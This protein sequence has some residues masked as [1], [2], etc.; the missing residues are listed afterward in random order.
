MTEKE[1]NS[2]IQYCLKLLDENKLKEAGTQL[3]NLYNFKPVRLCWYAAK[4]IC[5]WKTNKEAGA[6]LE[7]L[8]GKG[9]CFALYPAFDMLTRVYMDLVHSCGDKQDVKRH[10]MLYLRLCENRK[11]EDENWIIEMEKAFLQAKYDFL[12]QPESEQISEKLFD[13]YFIF[14]NN[15]LFYLLKIYMKKKNMSSSDKWEWFSEFINSGFLSENLAE[16]EETPFIIIEDE[17]SDGLDEKITT[18]ILQ[19]LQKK[20]YYMKAPIEFE[21]EH[22]VDIEETAAISINSMETAGGLHT[23]YPAEIIYNGEVQGDNREYILAYLIQND[24]RNQF[25]VVLTS[26]MM[27]DNFCCQPVLK[28]D[29]ERLHVFSS[30]VF[31]TQ[32][33][34]GW[35]G[36]YLAY[37]SQIHDMDARKFLE[38]PAEVSYSIIVPARNS[39]S[40]LRYTLMTCLNQ[41]YEGD[42][43]IVLSD[44]STPGNTEVYQL[45]KELSDPRIKYYKTPRE[46]NLSRS[47]EF[48]FLHAK[49]EF[50]LS[51]GSDDG[52]LPWTL[53]VLDD[54]RKDYPDEDILQWERGFYAWPGFAGGQQH[55]FI[56]PG[57]YKKG[58]YHPQYLDR[59]YYFN[60]FLNNGELMYLLPNLYL[61]SGCKRDYLK[62]I[63]AQTGRLF[64]GICQDLYMGVV[65]ASINEK[66]LKLDYPLIIAGVTGN[67]TGAKANLTHKLDKKENEF[68]NDLKKTANIGAYCS[69]VYERLMPEVTTDKSSLYNCILRMIARGV[70]TEKSFE[71]INF[72]KWFIDVF[73]QMDIRDPLFDRKLH[74]IRYT[75]SMHGEEFL[76]W[77]DE[78]IYHKALSPCMI[79]EKKIEKAEREKAYKEGETPLGA[80]TL[81]A[82]KYGVENI[83]DAAGLFEQMTGL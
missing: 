56:I 42:Y 54:I 67:S 32:M 76:R 58:D 28:K 68:L 41:R 73:R 40:T 52:L 17:N 80:R 3:D 69:S 82:S 31:E 29:L 39:A 26:G 57:K 33:A 2:K 47:F 15:I 64:D 25:A 77:F 21:V 35:A 19:R 46:Y 27:L 50:L 74:Y 51:L 71:N 53:E 36:D 18:Y 8:S 12:E 48:A 45:Y 49:G 79:D 59:Q 30:P 13:F 66:I 38:A 11:A 44:N 10:R 62:R 5:I 34:F 43:E 16:E 20:I 14:Q 83:Y 70:I 81:D 23:I 4:A 75:A 60:I 7:S 78:N 22:E 9:C 37:I 24:L 65:N 55:Q 72:S 61:N 6:A 1:Y 63:L